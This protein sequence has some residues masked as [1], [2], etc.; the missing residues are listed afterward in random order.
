MITKAICIAAVAVAVV[1]ILFLVDRFLPR[2]D[3]NEPSDKN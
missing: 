1:A 2:K 3:E